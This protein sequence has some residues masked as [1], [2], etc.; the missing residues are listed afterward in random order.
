MKRLISILLILLLSLGTIAGCGGSTTSEPSESG[1]SPSAETNEPSEPGIYDG[2]EPLAESVDLNI[3]YLNGSNH[4]AITWMIERFGGFEKVGI[5]LNVE[6][7][8]NGP[9]MVEALASD[10]WDCG[11]V[12]LGGTL[13]GVITQGMY[14]VGAAISDYETQRILARNDSDIVAD[15]VT[16]PEYNIYGKPETWK[17]KE[18]LLP[19]GTT[20]HYMLSVGVEKLGLSDKDVKITHMDV[21]NVNTAMRANQGELGGMWGNFVYAD[22]VPEKFT[23]VM[24]AADLG[25]NLPTVMVVNP[26]S[27]NDPKKYEA[28]K[29]W[30]ELY[31]ATIDW[32]TSSDEA[33]REAAEIFTDINEEQGVMGTVEEN[34]LVLKQ[35][36][37][38]LGMNH[39]YFNN[40]SADGKMLLIEEMHY[41]PL[42]FYIEQ[43]SYKPDAAEKLLGGFFKN[44]IINELYSAKK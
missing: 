5:N 15:G 3:G 21:T 35:E 11:T 37:Y 4:G 41:A 8:G 28:I 10:S 29:K 13:T 32:M 24:S 38:T 18:V 1:D 33:F 20:L 9:V 12:G 17:G 6:V 14:V 2:I 44:D 42:L 27:Y 22:D 36:C 30:M 16:I 25:I 19:N 43:G 31:F 7:F 23:V 26:K 34:M 39:D 40:K